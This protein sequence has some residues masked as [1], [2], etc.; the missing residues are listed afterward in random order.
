MTFSI[1]MSFHSRRHF[2]C[3]NLFETLHLPENESK[4]EVSKIWVVRQISKIRQEVFVLRPSVRVSRSGAPPWILKQG[5][6]ESSG[7]RLISSIGKPK[8]IAFF[9]PEKKK[10]FSEFFFR[11]SD[12][13]T[14]FDNFWIFLFFF[15]DFLDFSNFFGFFGFLLDFFLDFF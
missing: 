14:I 1:Q 9:Y 5:G 10:W 13:L 7:R 12:F 4:H 8:G 15:I 6:L 3:P 11:F 2:H